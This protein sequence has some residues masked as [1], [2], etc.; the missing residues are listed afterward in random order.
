MTSP[1]AMSTS[2]SGSPLA[3][4]RSGAPG[5]QKRRVSHLDERVGVVPLAA[6]LLELPAAVDDHLAVIADADGPA[7]QGSRGGPLEVDAGDLEAGAMAGAL[8]LL[9]AL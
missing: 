1:I 5:R 8:E 4:E 2:H 3:A 7:L 9:L 6:L